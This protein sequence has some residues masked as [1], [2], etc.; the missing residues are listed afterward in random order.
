MQIE[1]KTFFTLPHCCLL[2]HSASSS[3]AR[4]VRTFSSIRALR[5]TIVVYFFF[6]WLLLSPFA[7]LAAGLINVKELPQFATFFS[8]LFRAAV[9]SHAL[10]YAKPP[11]KVQRGGRKK[12][13]KRKEIKKIT[14]KKRR[15]SLCPALYASD[16]QRLRAGHERG[17]QGPK[18]CPR[19]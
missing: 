2:L 10:K 14:G 9:F 17:C 4:N 16:G 12:K 19:L 6:S 7:H 11:V 1:S 15:S 13:E 3:S 8:L 18:Q 5:S